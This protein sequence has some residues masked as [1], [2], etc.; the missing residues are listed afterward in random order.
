[1]FYQSLLKT[2][3][4]CKKR[5]LLFKP[6]DVILREILDKLYFLSNESLS[7][8]IS[9]HRQIVCY[10]FTNASNGNM[11]ILKFKQ[12]YIRYTEWSKQ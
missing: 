7:S 9:D 3:L 6:H 8:C 1:M 10:V 5:K 4:P 2:F 11:V 12:V